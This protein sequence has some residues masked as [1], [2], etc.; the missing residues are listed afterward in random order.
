MPVPLKFTERAIAVIKG[1]LGSQG[2]QPE[3]VIR[4]RIHPQVDISLALDVPTDGD[5][6]V[7]YQGDT[8]L[9]LK[10]GICVIISDV[11]VDIEENAQGRAFVLQ[12]CPL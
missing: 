10:P 7:E 2:R 12:L 11:I 4:L 6:E 3:Q 8:V 1:C 9:V 5:L